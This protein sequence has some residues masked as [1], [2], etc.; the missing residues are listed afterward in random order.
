MESVVKLWPRAV[1]S[2]ATNPAKPFVHTLSRPS[3][4]CRYKGCDHADVYDGVACSSLEQSCFDCYCSIAIET[5]A[6]FSYCQRYWAKYIVQ[7]RCSKSSVAACMVMWLSFHQSTAQHST[8]VPEVLLIACLLV[9]RILHVLCV[10]CSLC[11]LACACLHM[12]V[13]LCLS[14]SLLSI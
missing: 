6:G 14:L 1:I 2:Q 8:A 11:V 4:F 9:Y 3:M 13:S 10:S 7:V 5:F 12:S